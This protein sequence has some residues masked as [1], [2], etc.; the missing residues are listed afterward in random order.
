MRPSPTRRGIDAGPFRSPLMR[1]PRAGGVPPEPGA[2]W[3]AAVGAA[4]CLT[5]AVVA[6]AGGWRGAFD[7]LGAAFVLIAGLA[8]LVGSQQVP[9]GGAWPGAFGPAGLPAGALGARRRAGGPGAGGSDLTVTF[10]FA[11]LLGWGTPPALAA[12][13][14]VGVLLELV[15]GARPRW[16]MVVVGRRSLA[17][18]AAG[19]VVA[20]YGLGADLG[21]GD[22]P[23]VAL[24]GLA[25][26]AVDDLLGLP[27]HPRGPAAVGGAAG[28]GGG[29]AH[30]GCR[31]PLADL[32]RRVAG[33]VATL[34]L[35]PLV[36]VAA[37]RSAW[38]VPLLLPALLV[39]A[40]VGEV[41]RQK[42]HEA[43]HD[44]LT[45]L[46]N[47]AELAERAAASFRAAER[48]GCRVGLLLL[49]LDRF[50]EVNDRLGHEVGDRLLVVAAARLTAALRPGDVVARLG[51]DEFA[52]LLPALP[53]GEAG[54][55]VVGEVAGR[56]RGV[57][58]APYEIDGQFCDVDASVG[59][60]LYPDHGGD[61]PALSRCADLAMYT[62]KEHRLGV[63]A[64][65]PRDASRARLR[66]RT[67]AELGYALEHGQ[68]E[69]HYQPQ[70]EIADGRV[71]RV[72]A[73]L[74]WRH[75]SRGLLLPG[76]FVP[77]AE[78]AGLIRP[79][80]SWVMGRALAQVARWNAV[81]IPVAVALN[82]SAR[83]LRDP[84]FVGSVAAALAETGLPAAA[85]TF[86]VTEGA[87]TAD[88]DEPAGALRDLADLGVRV[89]LDDFGTGR[90]SLDALRRLPFEEIKIDR[91]VIGRMAGADRDADF[92]RA[93]VRMAADLGLRVVAEGVETPVEWRRLAG[94]GA[95]AAQGWHV[96]PALPAVL[97][98]PWLAAA[99]AETA[100]PPRPAAAVSG[101]QPCSAAGAGRA[102]EGGGDAGQVREPGHLGGAERGASRP[103]DQDGQ[104]FVPDRGRGE[105]HVDRLPAG[106]E[107]AVVR[108]DA[109]RRAQ[110]QPGQREAHPLRNTE[111]V[112]AQARRAHRGLPDPDVARPQVLEQQR[113]V[114]VEDP[115]DQVGQHGHGVGGA[116]GERVDELEVLADPGAVGLVG[117][118]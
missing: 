70:A 116:F 104:P 26:F 71:R 34:S 46:P 102:G 30:A 40:R 69:V 8:L 21:A 112:A 33:G 76:V 10:L 118:Q 72:E 47:R 109:P 42:E 115:R 45:G 22:L 2:G 6:V 57:L 52:V 1:A 3:G 110:R 48:T 11:L 111:V 62:A 73:L 101:A 99:S 95:D 61:L 65:G 50:K 53:A 108:H 83:D 14:V 93:V 15:R 77:L 91:T 55:T 97:L 90:V 107:L 94:F 78:S 13:L 84:G 43:R 68:L 92:V 64:Y 98:T 35:A 87:V 58:R 51:G 41:S 25:L 18:C 31:A 96:A 23:E 19:A 75:P 88:G 63:Q 66:A 67:T 79:I 44:G 59:V 89:S 80:T 24:A 105:L 81:G 86:E 113:P 60:A 117:P 39:V 28:R 49:D 17:L 74:R 5:A 9:A 7:N 16:V 38:L 85:L 56:V 4:G 114:G 12:H 32:R 37:A 29:R 106:R 54:R 20:A 103:A 100:A 27:T 36:V 82:A